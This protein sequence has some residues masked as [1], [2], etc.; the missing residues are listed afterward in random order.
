MGTKRWGSNAT[1]T[2]GTFYFTPSNDAIRATNYI[3][4]TEDSYVDAIYVYCGAHDGGN[5]TMKFG[6]F[7]SGGHLIN[8]QESNAHTYGT[9]YGWNKGD[10]SAGSFLFVPSGTTFGAAVLAYTQALQL[11]G[12]NDGG[13]FQWWDAGSAT[14]LPGTWSASGTIG[15]VGNFGW[16]VTYFPAARITSIPTSPV[17]IGQIITVSGQSFSAGVQ[18][19]SINGTNCPMFSVVNDTTLS[20][21]VPS[22]ATS[23]PVVVVT[24]AGTATSAGNLQVGS[25]YADNGASFVAGAIAYADNGTSWQ[26]AT[27]WAD[28]GTSWVQIG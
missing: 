26:Q 1:P 4:T 15:T 21:T 25:I 18:S 12:Y 2:G 28:T 13:T 27:I 23:G 9:G 5:S 22:G 11:Q 19:V 17:T 3:T 20:V 7:G 16:Y 10:F 6:L 14:D 24:N 8:G